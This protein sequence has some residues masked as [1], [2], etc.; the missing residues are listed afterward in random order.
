MKCIIFADESYC[1]TNAAAKA[2]RRG[3]IVAEDLQHMLGSLLKATSSEDQTVSHFV[4]LQRK[5]QPGD[6]WP[7]K[8]RFC[9]LQYRRQL[10]ISG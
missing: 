8:P 10:S 9:A 2:T 4:E 7:P 1:G 3:C 6:L 5:T